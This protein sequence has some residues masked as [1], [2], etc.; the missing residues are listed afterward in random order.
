MRGGQRLVGAYVF[1]PR[2]NISLAWVK[3]ADVPKL[4]AIKRGCCGNR[5]R[6]IFPANEADLRH[7][8]NDGG[9]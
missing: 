7:W 6:V 4:F 8:K 9:R 5:K 2:A 1:V 3:E